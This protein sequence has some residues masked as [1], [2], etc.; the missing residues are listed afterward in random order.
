[1]ANIV[2]SRT[3]E[4]LQKLNFNYFYF[5][6]IDLNETDVGK[7]T[8]KI[9]TVCN[10]SS[11]SG[12]PSAV[13]VS[14]DLKMEA[15]AI[16]TDPIARKEEADRLKKL[17]L[18]SVSGIL[19]GLG[20]KGLIY[21]S[22]VEDIAK[23]NKLDVADVEGV[24]KDLV[25]NGVRYIDDTQNRFDV[26]NYNNIEK[27]LAALQG[28]YKNLYDLLELTPSSSLAEIQRRVNDYEKRDAPQW[29]KRGGPGE[30]LKQLYGCA[31][32]IFKQ[33]GDVPGKNGKRQ[34]DKYIA[35]YADVYK[36][37]QEK[38]KNGLTTLRSEEYLE[39]I[40]LIVKKSHCSLEEAEKDLAALMKAF[41]LSLLGDG[42][43]SGQVKIA[44]CPY[45]ACGKP[46]VSN[47][48]P[49]VCPHCGR[50]LKSSCWNCGSAMPV[51]DRSI[52]PSCSLTPSMQAPYL[53]GVE[54]M[55]GLLR[56]PM[57]SLS[58]LKSSLSKLKSLV[59]TYSK[60]KGSETDKKIDFFERE[61]AAK[62]RA[63]EG[64]LDQY[65][66]LMAEVHKHVSAKTFFKAKAALADL[67]RK[68]PGYNSGEV[69]KVQQDI[70]KAINESNAQ[71]S[72]AKTVPSGS[73]QYINMVAKALELCSDNLEAQQLLKKYPPVAPTALRVK[74]GNKG[75]ASLEW[76]VARDQGVIEYSVIRKIGSQPRS[77]TDG[78]IVSKGLTIS[79][80]EDATV[81]AACKCYYGVFGSRF[82][83]DTPITICPTPI[84]S[85]PDVTEFTQEI[86]EGVISVKWSVPSIVKRIM[87]KKKE[88]AGNANET[89]SAVNIAKKDGFYDD[90]CHQIGDSYFVQCVYEIEGKEYFSK[91][92][93]MFFKP[94]FMPK[95][96]ENLALVNDGGTL[97]ITGMNI[98]SDTK[99]YISKAKLN[100]PLGKVEK[101]SSLLSAIKGA[102]KLSLID[103]GDE[104]FSFVPPRG[105][106]GFLYAVNANDEFYN[107]SAPIFFTT[108]QGIS[109][110]NF[111]EKS[112]SVLIT[113]NFAP[114]LDSVIVKVS[115]KKFPSSLN[116]E[117]DEFTV[118]ASKIRSDGGILFKPRSD[119]VSYVTLFAK[120][121]GSNRDEF[122][123]G[124]AV[125]LPVT[126][127]NRRKQIVK[128]ALDY[129]P[130]GGPCNVTIKFESETEIELPEFVLVKANSTPL[131]KGAGEMVTTFLPPATKKGL[132]THGR[133]LSKITVH[134][135]MLG[136]FEKI[137]IFF[138]EDGP[139]KIQMKQ[140]ANI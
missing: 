29:A 131:N 132:F 69:M 63:E 103:M 50:P 48:N 107:A 42:S 129:T 12:D 102:S 123:V 5:F 110:P 135:P 89:G 66:E 85:F 4:E 136:K 105:F 134:V 17:R 90:K 34:Y 139:K 67:V 23:K 65:R 9:N 78:T 111:V 3:P 15:I 117:G 82:G 125:P 130:K 30:S 57:T 83:V 84:T 18:A 104:K 113:G 76:D 46:Y 61:L 53:K 109:M 33:E 87:M 8:S 24:M 54:E 40:D 36:P 22:E 98:S 140:I 25:K 97:A 106:T 13:R 108:E 43:V 72:R 92:V 114:S 74:L 96:I 2:D 16:M 47:N 128:Y 86:K 51:G 121:A 52:C 80:Y 45:S 58:S 126:I 19:A 27:Y 91:G 10:T 81:P 100:I 14:K 37:M 64:K 127:D 120:M 39:Y 35:I 112:G 26:N 38:Q 31:H 41:K 6:A 137:S 28:K 70:D 122:A 93:N 21:K 95:K 77:V 124:E 20:Q 44:L 73:S 88:G 11:T 79:F 99:V 101:N 60:V 71:L 68:L 56:N 115:L 55:N 138:A 119:S 118:S 49:A 116:D 62:E 94:V 7:I 133:F 1:M 75:Q 59:P 32:V